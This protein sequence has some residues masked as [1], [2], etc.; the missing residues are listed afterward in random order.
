MEGV[1]SRRRRERWNRTPQRVLALAVVIGVLAACAAPP[2]PNGRS[3]SPHPATEAS[4][5]PG[6]PAFGA[7]LTCPGDRWPPPDLTGVPG[8]RVV[9]LDRATVEI[10]NDTDQTWYYQLSGWEVAMLDTCIGL[11]PIEI[12]RGPLPAG[13]VERTSLGQLT[14]QADLP[15]TIAF[16][17][18]PCGEAC[19]RKAD[20]PM[21]IDR[22]HV[23]PRSS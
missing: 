11:I 13:A 1:A 23:E 16:W 6:L 17:D 10:S 21:L 8:I 12:E 5:P 2:E 22:S 14:D 9:A 15:V 19:V 3:F 20:H 4:T 7:G 18:A